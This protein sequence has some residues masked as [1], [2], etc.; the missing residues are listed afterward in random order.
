L[1]L[2][3]VGAILLGIFYIPPRTQ[4]YDA[5]PIGSPGCPQPA[6]LVAAGYMWFGA[7]INGYVVRVSYGW[8]HT[9]SPVGEDGLGHKLRRAKMGTQI[10]AACAIQ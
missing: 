9:M 7:I 1:V 8:F 6:A 3:V 4:T 5:T 2:L 10:L